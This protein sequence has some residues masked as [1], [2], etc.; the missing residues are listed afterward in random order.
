VVGVVVG[1]GVVA[2]VEVEVGV[3]PMTCDKCHCAVGSMSKGLCRHCR[4][5]GWVARL[6]WRVLPELMF[7]RRL[8]QNLKDGGW[9]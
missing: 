6:L 5:E 2:G 7:Q 4:C 8:R 1:V 9:L 3:D